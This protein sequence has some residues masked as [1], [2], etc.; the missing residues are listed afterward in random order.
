MQ[1]LYLCTWWLALVH[2]CMW[3]IG[4]ITWPRG[5][6]KFLFECWK[7]FRLQNSP[8]FCVFRYARAVKQK[9]WNE[10][11]N[12]RAC[13]AR[14]LGARKTLTP[15]FTDFFTDFEKKKPTVL[16]SKKYFTSERSERVKYFFNTRRESGPVMFYL[17]YKHQWNTKPFHFNSFWCER[18]DLLCSQSKGDIFPC[19]DNMLFSHVATSSC[20]TKAHLVFHWFLYN[21]VSY[22]S[23]KHCRKWLP[24]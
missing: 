14:A 18:R 17:L 12:S 2:L 7:I 1:F 24:C 16:Q 10:A 11:E 22:F 5:D 4:D 21:K 23:Q 15:R 8:Y 6:T 3:Y 20:R 9:V 13:E 19:E